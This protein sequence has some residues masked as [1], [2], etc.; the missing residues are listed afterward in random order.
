M[1]IKQLFIRILFWL[2][3]ITNTSLTAYF[4]YW[5]MHSN[6]RWTDYLLFILIFGTLSFSFGPGMVLAFLIG[7]L[8][9]FLQ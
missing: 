6:A 9:G 3:S 2:I 4:T 8:I 7:I 5:F 1:A